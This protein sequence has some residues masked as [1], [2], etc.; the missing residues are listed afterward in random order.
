MYLGG[1]TFLQEAVNRLLT[2]S[3]LIPLSSIRCDLFTLSFPWTGSTMGTGAMFAVCSLVWWT[4]EA[5]GHW[6]NE[7]MNGHS[8]RTE[9]MGYSERLR[10]SPPL[11]SPP[12]CLLP[13]TLQDPKW[14]TFTGVLSLHWRLQPGYGVLFLV[15]RTLFSFP[16]VEVVNWQSTNIPVTNLLAFSGVSSFHTA[17]W[18][19]VKFRLELKGKEGALKEA[20]ALPIRLPG[21]HMDSVL[22]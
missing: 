19:V 8:L 11:S 15:L 14:A 22:Y 6:M 1:N 16:V 18:N 5:V 9:E 20:M 17:G 12:L 3:F 13:G 4:Q 10:R 2:I 7:W 21:S